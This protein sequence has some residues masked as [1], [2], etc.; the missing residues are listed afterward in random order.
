MNYETAYHKLRGLEVRS[1]SQV[2]QKFEVVIGGCGR[3][4]NLTRKF[5]AKSLTTAVRK[6]VKHF[7]EVPQRTVRI[8]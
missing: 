6:T 7:V 3:K 2:G 1:V 8:G 4:F 5:S